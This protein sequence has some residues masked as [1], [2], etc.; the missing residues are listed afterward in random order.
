MHKAGN[1][2]C[3]AD[4]LP[5]NFKV[6]SEQSVPIYQRMPTK[7]KGI[8]FG[9]LL[10]KDKLLKHGFITQDRINLVLDAG[11]FWLGDDW[12][13]TFPKE[14][15]EGVIRDYREIKQKN[16]KII[17]LPQA[18]GPFE[19]K[20]SKEF[21]L[22]IDKYVDHYFVRDD[23]SMGYMRDL[24][25]NS[26]LELAHDFTNL[27]SGQIPSEL[28]S[29]VHDKV[30]I[31]PNHKIE[32]VMA[33]DDYIELMQ[34]CVEKIR[35]YGLDAFFLNHEGIKDRKI[36]DRINKKLKVGLPIVDNLS[37]LSVKG[38]I[39]FSYA[40]VC[41]RFHGVVSALSQGVPALATSWSHKYPELLKA[42]S[43]D[44]GIIY[45]SSELEKKLDMILCEKSNKK[46]REHLKKEAD[47]L[48]GESTQ[49]ISKLFSLVNMK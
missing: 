25:D 2:Y 27:A 13:R 36:I 30:C 16:G 1:I 12:V 46:I 33:M 4:R 23:V 32:S 48:K 47:R 6:L 24:I 34:L 35:A 21:L 14:R 44:E 29:F 18:Y 22:D 17:F 45:D 37:A 39:G 28:A 3:C 26:K 11:G 20:E 7:Y 19:K 10:P 42:Y 9:F 8:D 40:V 38:V 31:V 15:R 41:S 43:Y 5:G 49:M